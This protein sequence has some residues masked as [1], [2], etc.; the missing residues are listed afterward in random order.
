TVAVF[1]N[2]PNV[3][4]AVSDSVIADVAPLARLG[5]VQVTVPEASLH[6]QPE[7]DALTKPT[8]A[9][10]GSVT[11]TFAASVAPLLVT[12]SVSSNACPGVTGSMLSVFVID[13]SGASTAVIVSELIPTPRSLL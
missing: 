3:F 10:S 5:R 12:E 7:P 1:V 2:V 11:V 13:R 8:P 6:V 9:G 4:G